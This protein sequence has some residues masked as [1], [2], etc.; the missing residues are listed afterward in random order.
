MFVQVQPDVLAG[1]VPVGYLT[2][3]RLCWAGCAFCRLASPP[4]AH[5]RPKRWNP[6]NA[7]ATHD[8][9]RIRVLKVRGGLSATE[10][11]DHWVRFLRQLAP[12]LAPGTIMLAFSPVE[13]WHYHVKERRSLR[14]LA[15]LLVW[16][17]ATAI[18]PGGSETWD[19][20][21]RNRWAP[22]RLTVDQWWQVVE[23]AE[24]VGLGYTLGP[25]AI[26][27][28]SHDDWHQYLQGIRPVAPLHIEIKPLNSDNTPLASEGHGHVLEVGYAAQILR[29]AFPS[30]PIY[31]RWPDPS[32]DVAQILG[33]SG[34][35]GLFVTQWE[36]SS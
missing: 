7:I 11:F 22:H 16:A 28:Q 9:S 20:E 31:V 6:D 14:E 33:A 24:A 18:G 35:T 15:R 17:G 34:V 32:P 5:D 29:A 25:M 26:P 10:P 27:R 8:L 3:S 4:T 30:V 23:C 19:A 36:V 2:T 13:L 12:Q 1:N 21:R